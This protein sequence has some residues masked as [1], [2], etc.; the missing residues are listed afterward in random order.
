M[1]SLLAN[2]DDYFGPF[3]LFGYVSTRVVAAAFTSFVLM[4]IVM[5]PLIRWLKRK[6]FGES[7]AK[8]DGAVVA[9]TYQ[10]PGQYRVTA[11]CSNDS[12]RSLQAS[13]TVVIVKEKAPKVPEGVIAVPGQNPN[14]PTPALQP[15][16]CL[17]RERQTPRRY[18]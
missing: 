4:M 3:R 2:L 1:L 11:L 17:S 7:G 9:H 18:L 12:G 14:I 10:T 16:A 6:K 8:G 5:P 13:L 15:L